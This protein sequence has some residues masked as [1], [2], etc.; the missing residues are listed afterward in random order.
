MPWQRRSE[1]ADYTT[2]R[3]AKQLMDI[4]PGFCRKLDIRISHK[5]C[6]KTDEKEGQRKKVAIT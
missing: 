5:M 1:R 4:A 3:E 6:L 2:L